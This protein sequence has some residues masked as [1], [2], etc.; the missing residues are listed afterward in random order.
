MAQEG[1]KKLFIK[2]GLLIEK[3]PEEVFQ[4]IVNPEQMKN[5]FIK[6]ASGPM[7]E[8]KTVFWNFPEF[9]KKFPVMTGNILKNKYISFRWNSM[10]GTET[11][12]EITLEEKE[13]G[14]TYVEITEKE[15][16]P[17]EAGLEWLKSNTGGWANFLAF[18]KAWLEYGINLRKKAFIRSQ[19]PE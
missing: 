9:E 18:L 16:E 7:E 11:L 19:L 17:D 5:Y 1:L 13:P 10:D 2:T 8:G 4:A 3:S 15:R 12:V 14:L 6:T